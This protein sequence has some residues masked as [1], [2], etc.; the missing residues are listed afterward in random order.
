MSKT[1][2]LLKMYLKQKISYLSDTE[3]VTWI[4]SKYFNSI[5]QCIHLPGQAVKQL[6]T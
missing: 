1:Y 5:F 6:L 4:D 3:K 2:F